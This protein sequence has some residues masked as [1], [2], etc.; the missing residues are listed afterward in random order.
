MPFL[1]LSATFSATSTA[2]Y[3]CLEALLPLPPLPLAFRG[4]LP[5]L[6]A[7]PISQRRNIGITLSVVAD[8][9]SSLVDPFYLF[10]RDAS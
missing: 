4:P 3:L 10:A 1:V 5:L 6:L 7:A 2:N 8:R 9:S